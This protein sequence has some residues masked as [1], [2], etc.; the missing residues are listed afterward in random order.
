MILK[1]MTLEQIHVEH[2]QKSSEVKVQSEKE[3]EKEMSA[4]HKSVSESHKTNTREKKKGEEENLITTATKSEM[5]DVRNNTNQ[6]FII[7]VYKD[8]LFPTNDLT[9]VPSVV[10]HV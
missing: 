4:L 7:I 5:R 6:V 10:T 1:P 3:K 2:M 9:S 8:T